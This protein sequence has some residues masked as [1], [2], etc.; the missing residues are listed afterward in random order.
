MDFEPTGTLRSVT[1]QSLDLISCMSSNIGVS[2]LSVTLN[3]KSGA[4]SAYNTTYNLNMSVDDTLIHGAQN[5]ITALVDD[6]LVAYASRQMVIFGGTDLAPVLKQFDAVRL[7]SARFI[8]ISLGINVTLVLLV[9]AETIRTKAWQHL[10]A[11]DF[12]DLQSVMAAAILSPSHFDDPALV[13]G[14]LKRAS[15]KWSRLKD[16]NSVDMLVKLP[17]DTS[18]ESLHSAKSSVSKLSPDGI[19]IASTEMRERPP[20]SQ[21]PLLNSTTEAAPLAHPQPDERYLQDF[22]SRRP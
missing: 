6:L 14:E 2:T 19:D 21:E 22:E 3:T 18:H 15:I 9:L 11:F 4:V 5:M 16:N 20:E 17:G 1:M 12:T 8:Y 13:T 7:G 10:P